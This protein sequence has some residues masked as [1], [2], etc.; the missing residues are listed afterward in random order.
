MKTI[1]GF[2]DRFGVELR[3]RYWL[4]NIATRVAESFGYEPISVP[5][6]ERAEAY[7]PAIVGLSPWPEWNP[8]GCFFFSIDN[9]VENYSSPDSKTAAVLIPEGTLSVTRWLGSQLTKTE[10]DMLPLKIYYDLQ[11]FRNELISTLNPSKGRS[12]SQ[13][14]LE[15][16]GAHSILADIEQMVIAHETL[17]AFGVSGAKIVFRM[18]SNEIFLSMAEMTGLTDKSRV[19]AKESLDTIAE[20]KAGKR[21]E[22][23]KDATKLFWSIINS[24]PERSLDNAWEYI[25]K[26]NASK[27]IDE[28]DWDM[29]GKY[30]PKSIERLGAIARALNTAD[31]PCEIDFCVVRSHEYYTGIT[32]E[33]DFVGKQTRYV[34]VGGGGRYD[35]L[36]GNFTPPTGPKMVPCV[37]FAFGVERLQSALE[38]EGLFQKDVKPQEKKFDLAERPDI[39]SHEISITGNDSELAKEYIQSAIALRNKRLFKRISITI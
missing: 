14:G 38:S 12:F 34:E 16:L 3:R 10:T 13:F 8:N 4:T 19:V 17:T 26:R 24:A 11:C 37:G 36:L 9:Y 1:V 33:I 18:S 31:M 27:D 2:K 6:I 39:D 20:C 32:F 29:L 25:L 30:A 28:Q 5:P 22:R 7:D 15:I 35:R 21:P 23:L